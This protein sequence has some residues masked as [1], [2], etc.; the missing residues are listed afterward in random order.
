MKEHPILFSAQMVQA[1]LKDRK[2]QTRRV[3][4][5]PTTKDLTW[6][7]IEHQVNQAV[8]PMPKGGFVFWSSP[9]GKEFSDRA[10]A[11]SNDGLRCPYGQVGDR[12]WVRETWQLWQ[13]SGSVGDEFI[14]DEVM[15]YE[16]KIP[17]QAPGEFSFWHIAYKA[18][19]EDSMNWWR[20]SIFMPRW[21]SRITLEIVNIRVEQ[22]QEIDNLGALYEGTP[23]LRTMEN[24][25]D[26][27]RC[28]QEL[29]DSINEPRG[30]GW[31][32]NP[33]VWV[34]E[35][36]RTDLTSQAAEAKTAPTM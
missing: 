33:W 5:F 1:I 16:G 18:D 26:L 31:K 32:V 17:K 14:G 10:Y 3:V 19:C 4:K 28:F 2:T 36:Q 34:I 29:W 27:R 25:W 7:L 23:D 15:E 6:Q 11:D 12:L 9:V 20:P 24:N 13:S 35:F 8:Y 21:A 22:V 30:F